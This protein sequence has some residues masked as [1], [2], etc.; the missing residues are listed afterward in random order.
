M[1]NGSVQQNPLCAASCQEE[2]S[3]LSPVLAYDF[4]S[5]CKFSTPTI[6]AQQHWS[7]WS[8]HPNWSYPRECHRYGRAGHFYTEC[9]RATINPPPD[10]PP[11]PSAHMSY[12]SDFPGP[13]EPYIQHGPPPP[14]LSPSPPP[15][16]ANADAFTAIK[17]VTITGPA[18]TLSIILE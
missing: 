2:S 14:S 16:S 4:L 12:H 3:H 5:Q 1:Y 15:H 9:C 6:G 18:E 13:S 7:L 8:D 10:Q 11:L 17:L